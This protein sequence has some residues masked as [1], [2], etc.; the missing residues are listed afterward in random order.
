MV[1]QRWT[2][3]HVSFKS[4][5][6]GVL[7][8][9]FASAGWV[10]QTISVNMGSGC[11]RFTLHMQSWWRFLEQSMSMYCGLPLQ[12]PCW[13]SPMH[14]GTDN[15]EWPEPADCAETQ[16]LVLTQERWWEQAGEGRTA[17]FDSTTYLDWHKWTITPHS[18]WFVWDFSMLDS[19]GKIMVGLMFDEAFKDLR[20]V[21]KFLCFCLVKR[22]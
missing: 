17:P 2:S 12:S 10:V 9:S 15:H 6:P 11:T 1:T 5:T 3:Q 16:A 22:T 13:C 4:N 8:T 20:P 14:F 21:D 7:W 18:R 19:P